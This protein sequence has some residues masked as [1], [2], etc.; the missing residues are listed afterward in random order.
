MILALNKIEK[1]Y[2]ADTILE[3]ITFHIE[4]REKTA[5][6]GVNGAGKTTLFRILTGEISADGGDIFLKKETSLG[7]MAQNQQIESTRTIYE[8]ML[9]VFENISI[10]SSTHSLIFGSFGGFC[11]KSLNAVET[12]SKISASSVADSI[13]FVFNNSQN[14]PLPPFLNISRTSWPLPLKPF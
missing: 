12:L 8:E 13:P 9:S 6:V 7:Y 2:G 1:S 4:E 14:L 3:Q 11:A 5:I 10:A